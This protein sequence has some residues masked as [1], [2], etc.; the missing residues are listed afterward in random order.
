MSLTVDQKYELITRNLQEKIVDEEIIKKILSTRPLKIYWGT[1]PTS[2]PHLGYFAPMFKIIDFLQADC[3]VIIL[4]A[5]LH[6]VLDSMKS[7]FNQIEARSK[8]YIMVIQELLK[9]LGADIT[10]IKFIKGTEFQ[11][12]ED[13]TLDMYKAHTL[14]S[15]NDAKHAGAE[16]VKQDINPKMAGLMYPTLQALDEQYLGVDMSLGGNDQRRIMMHARTILPLLGYKK[17]SQLMNGMVPGVRFEKRNESADDLDKMSS[18]NVDTKISLLDTKNIIKNKINRSYCLAGD[19]EDNCLLEMT[20]RIIFPCLKL[21]GLAFVINRRAE[22]GGTITYTN[23]D[24]LK[25]DFAI[26]KM[27]PGDLKVG[28]ADNLDLIIDPIRSAFKSKDMIA[29]LNKAYP[30]K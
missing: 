26:S 22:Y 24:D 17:R 4:I 6:A 12:N 27:H 8:I 5:D 11:L 29:L 13:Y 16:V 25:N 14:I 19:A 23:F 30:N 15:I 10:K 2:M 28:I 1:A 18:S 20:D 9:S 3:E 21:K 7:T